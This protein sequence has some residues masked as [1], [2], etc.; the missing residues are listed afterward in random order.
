MEIYEFI[1]SVPNILDQNIYLFAF[2][3]FIIGSALASL[4]GLVIYRLPQQLELVEG[5]DTS[6]TLSSPPS[7]CETC[8]SK[9]KLLHLIPIFGWLIQMGKCSNCDAKIPFIYPTTEFFFG[10]I[11]A[12]LTLYLGASIELF[13]ICILIISLWVISWID[14]NTT[15]I[16]D[17]ITTPIML[18]GLVISPFVNNNYESALGA[19]L[20]WLLFSISFNIVSKLKSVDA[21][22]GG[23]VAMG[24]LAGAW[25]GSDHIFEYLFLAS[26]I[27]IFHALP[28]RNS[29]KIWVPM[30]PALSIALL[31][32]IFLIYHNINII[33]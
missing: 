26:I 33:S 11:F 21:Y 17:T 18:I 24:I 16:P 6:L 13:S 5:A 15:Y 25:I 4:S 29:G 20:G 27:F 32:K 3:M 14:W 12:S 1:I 10:G 28:Y 22:A 31:I 7:H 30:G 23:D 19:L 8:K 2:Y 9:I